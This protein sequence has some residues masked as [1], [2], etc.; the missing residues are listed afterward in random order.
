MHELYD[1]TINKYCAHDAVV[2]MHFYQSGAGNSAAGYV[3]HM[4]THA[5]HIRNPGPATVTIGEIGNSETRR[6]TGGD[7]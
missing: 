2:V 1:E 7:P 3:E 5:D 6:G 4:E